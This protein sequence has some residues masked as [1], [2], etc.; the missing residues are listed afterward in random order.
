VKVNEVLDLFVDS[1]G[2]R[3]QFVEAEAP[4]H[5]AHGGLAD[6]ANRVVDVLD[7]DHFSGL[8]M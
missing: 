6:L 5:V 2:I 8:V 1:R 3:Q 4:D 7:R